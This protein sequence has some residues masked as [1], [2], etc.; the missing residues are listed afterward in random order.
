MTL[1]TYPFSWTCKPFGKIELVSSGGTEL[2]VTI[3]DN[4]N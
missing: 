2:G 3:E 4:T 1:A